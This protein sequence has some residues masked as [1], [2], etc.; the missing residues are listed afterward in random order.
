MIDL[1]GSW[2]IRHVP[3]ARRPLDPSAWNLVVGAMLAVGCSTSIPVAETGAETGETG[4]STE[5]GESETGTET[6]AEETTGPMPECYDDADCHPIESCVEGICT[7]IAEY[8]CGSDDECDPWEYCNHFYNDCQDDFM[9][10]RDPPKACP[11]GA[12]DIP[13]ELSPSE[14]PLALRFVDIDG[15]GDQELAVVEASQI[16]VFADGVLLG[17]TPR[18]DL[19]E[20]ADVAVG[21]LDQA[22]GDDLAILDAEGSVHVYASNGVDG[23]AAAVGQAAA[24]PGA[25][26][27]R[28][29]DFDEVGPEDYLFWGP[30]GALL[31]PSEG[32]PI[33]LEDQEAVTDIAFH[34]ATAIF[35]GAV[36]LI[37]P[38]GI[39]KV[40]NLEGE[41]F[42]YGGPFE[43]E[44][45]VIAGRLPNSM[46]LYLVPQDTWSMIE[47]WRLTTDDWFSQNA[48]RFIHPERIVDFVGGDFNDD[49][50]TDVAGITEEGRLSLLL[51]IDQDS[52]CHRSLSFE[53]GEAL[54]VSEMHAG[55]IDGDGGA[56]LAL[57]VEGGA[58]PILIVD[59][60]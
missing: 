53:G 9:N 5:T 20:L 55:D 41:Y 31:A 22:M 39:A 14:E 29:A 13:L 30:S 38:E 8:E 6:G 56:E 2:H 58:S 45:P 4:M 1:E 32:E 24:L 60:D 3:P 48:E 12:G 23:F 59:V 37:G 36:A 54:V 28:I 46:L 17:S 11:A 50:R 43:P 15:D 34:D 51:D 27:F 35:G 7:Y 18:T 16:E 25:T 19:G 44:G 47:H 42:G 26:H 21:E 40:L 33:V 10:L 49:G 52:F 57:R